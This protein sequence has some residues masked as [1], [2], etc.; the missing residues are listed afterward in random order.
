MWGLHR[1]AAPAIFWTPPRRSAIPS[2]G[3][4][5]QDV[6]DTESDDFRRWTLGAILLGTVLRLGWD[7]F[8]GT[9]ILPE[10]ARHW[11]HGQS[12]GWGYPSE[13]PLT[14]WLVRASAEMFGPTLFGVRAFAP[15]LH[16][17][18]AWLI[19]AA[20]RHLFGEDEEGPRVGFWAAL[21]YLVMPGVSVS[22][23]FMTTDPPLMLAWALAVYALSRALLSGGT[24]WWAL[25]GA[26]IGA[27]Y[28]A[29]PVM[30]V[31]V[32]G[33]LGYALVHREG[34]PQPTGAWIA[35]PIAIA[36]A[37][38]NIVWALR[39]GTLPPE[40]GRMAFDLLGVGE[41]IGGQFAVFGPILFAALV[42]TVM[43]G[44]EWRRDWR[45]RLMLWLSLPVIALA[46]LKA[47]LTDAPIHAAAPAYIA[48]SIAAS[49]LLVRHNFSRLL[50]ISV[51]IGTAVWVGYWS[52]A[53]LYETRHAALPRN[54]DP[55][56]NLRHYQPV[57]KA[58]LATLSPTGSLL[59][60]DSRLLAVC[61]FE[62]RLGFER[63]ALWPPGTA[64]ARRFGAA[65]RL[66]G[67]DSRGFTYVTLRDAAERVKDA[68]ENAEAIS[69][70][71]VRSHRDRTHPAAVW[72]VQGY[73]PKKE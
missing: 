44:K 56:K 38:P 11:V 29:D 64:Q 49:T 63:V 70:V 54:L 8:A 4:R 18:A 48:G 46:A 25:L 36:L 50:Q 40:T 7:G 27:G 28:L 14:A 37:A 43:R 19:F 53:S 73:S 2:A 62:G 41:F 31:F 5:S 68:F 23:G 6:M 57:C 35:A 22:S 1:A 30:L 13:Q 69:T 67:E 59:A 10:E 42:V 16:G 21:A 52:L 34:A 26:A 58:A 15:L 72:S 71:P 45:L 60:D 65:A 32:L 17:L 33:A 47:Y 61:M 66:K 39:N 12:L 24:L 9:P 3:K 20:A 51:A 55:F